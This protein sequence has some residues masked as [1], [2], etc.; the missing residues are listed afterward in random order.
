MNNL[1]MPWRTGFAMLAY[2]FTTIGPISTAMAQSSDDDEELEEIIVTGTQIRGASITEALPVTVMDVASIEATG[3]SSGDD[4]FRDLAGAGAVS[5]G[6]SNT[7]SITGGVNGA[8]GDVSSI[9]LRSL[10]TGNT[11]VLLNGRRMVNH[12][13][14]Q[15][16]PPGLVPVTSANMNSIP[17]LGLRRVEVLR[18]G[19]SA[20]YGT[21]AIAGVINNVLK[22]DYEGLEMS[23]KY[24]APRDSDASDLTLNIHGGVTFNNGNTN[25]SFETTFYTRDPMLASD[26]DYSN[27]RDL[28][29]QVVGTLFEGDSQFRNTSGTTPWGT[30]R[31]PNA[32]T[33]GG[34]SST[35]FHVQPATFAGC[36]APVPNQAGLCFDD[37]SIDE[38]LRYNGNL[39]V[40]E[41]TMNNEVDRLNHFMTFNHSFENSLELYGEVGLFFA[42]SSFQRAFGNSPLGSHPMQIAANQAYNPFGAEF[43]PDGITPNPNRIPGLDILEVPTGGLQIPYPGGTA[44]R[45]LDGG[46]R[47]IKVRDRSWRYVT[48]LR[49]ELFDTGWDFDTGVV[50]SEAISKDRTDDRMSSTR[51]QAAASSTDPATAYNFWNGAGFDSAGNPNTDIDGTPN[52]AALMDPI[53]ISSFKDTKATLALVDFKVSKP[54]LFD[55]WGGNQVGFAVGTEFRRERYEDDRDPRLDG[56]VTFTNLAGRLLFSDT[57]NSS[58]TPDTSGSRNVWSAFAEFS[59]PIVNE[60]MNIPGIQSLDFQIAGRFEDFS[61]VGNIFKPR[62]AMG[63]RPLDQLLVRASYSEGYRV[64]NLAQT[65]DGVTIRTRTVND[66]YYCQ[67]QVNNGVVANMSACDGNI[68]T[69]ENVIN[70]GMERRSFGTDQLI[71]EETENVSFGVV[72]TPDYISGLTVTVDYWEITQNDLVGLF[73]SP[74]HMSLDWAMRINGLGGNPLLIRTDPTPED[75]AFFAGSGLTPVGRGIASLDQ[76]LNFD[77]RETRGFDYEIH[78]RLDDLSFGDLVFDFGVARI[79]QKEQTVTG[80]GAFINAQNEPAVLVAGGGD[81]LKRDRDPKLRASGSVKWYYENWNASVNF[82]HVGEFFDTSVN[83][84]AAITDGNP[85][86]WWTVDDWTTFGARVGYAFDSG[87]ME[88]GRVTLGIRNLTDE[89]P[90]LADDNFGFVPQMH[91]A[92]GRYWYVSA[93][94]EF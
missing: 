77:S 79:V 80:P 19:A 17:I 36:L 66:W 22:S 59:V 4:L 37:G 75:I 73:G 72:W 53:Y 35:T 49:G 34:V 33:L 64:P 38:A 10:G 82:N 61:D 90:P 65:N 69:S 81:L 68:G 24:G 46:N 23:A 12:P 51:F 39:D 31:L 94:Y 83:N 7:R 42:E 28:R 48:G 85:S 18:D 29:P 92:Y 16:D 74:N 5:F 26:R 54:D 21:D 11:L 89:D 6:G 84:S 44:Y 70:Y 3:A 52:P 93:R 20:I 56:T 88:G 32:V 27:N 14:V 86:G 9:N 58:P 41:R 62:I 71:P 50:Y 30:F 15:T 13:T 78:Y 63:W 25:V 87:M 57:M 47:L 76:Y 91:S 8:R 43:L 40:G 55:I 45:V 1:T 67:A 60:D 2:V